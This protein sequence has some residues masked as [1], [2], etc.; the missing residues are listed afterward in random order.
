MGACDFCFICNKKYCP[1]QGKS[2][3]MTRDS[4]TLSV[5]LSKRLKDFCLKK[6]ITSGEKYYRVPDHNAAISFLLDEYSKNEKRRR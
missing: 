4:I 5:S 3:P 2:M 6:K 1:K